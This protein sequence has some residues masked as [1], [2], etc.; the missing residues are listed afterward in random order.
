MDKMMKTGKILGIIT[1]RGGSKGIPKKNMV[2]VNKKPLITYTIKAAL[3][4]RFLDKIVVSSDD[5]KILRIARQYGV[6]AIKR[7]KAL[8]G[9]KVSS[10]AVITQ[11]LKHLKKNG[12]EYSAF[13][14]LQPT[15]PLRDEIDIDAAV[16]KFLGSDALALVS[17]YE[18]KHT[19]YKAFT[20]SKEG[21]L[22]GIVND[23]FPYARRQDLP[24]ALMPNGAIY[25]NDVKAF[26]IK[27]N[28]SR[29]KVIPYIMPLGK[30]IDIDT[31][32]DIR[33][34]EK[35]LKKKHV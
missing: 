24:L 30:S 9:D 22:K 35:M 5:N 10:Q 34:A 1:A 20:C 27:R 31:R 26:G 12:E 15:S 17:V 4:S 32:D 28:F 11:V 25:I 29:G 18:P 33:E 13:V 8:A 16:R 6:A 21:F 19:P 14:L 2:L 7:P 23:R 3:R